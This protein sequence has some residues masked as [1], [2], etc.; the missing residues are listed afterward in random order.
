MK[1]VEM[2]K[3][4]LADIKAALTIIVVENLHALRVLF[5]NI[6]DSTSKSERISKRT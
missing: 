5:K 4:L 6:A 3:K 1:G 2:L